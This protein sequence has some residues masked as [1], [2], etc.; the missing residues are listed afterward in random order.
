MCEHS[1]G[2]NVSTPST[3]F[4]G[5]SSGNGSVPNSTAT[6]PN[7]QETLQFERAATAIM[8]ER[9]HT[10]SSGTVWIQLNI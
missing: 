2:S 1:G 4:A 9:P 5:N 10:I 7:L 8:N 3:P 6:W